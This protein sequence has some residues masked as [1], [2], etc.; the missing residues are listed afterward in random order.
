MS[1]TLG[2]LVLP[3][4]L[5]WSDEHA[6]SPIAQSTEYG[7]TGSLIVD[8]A[9]KQAGRPITLTGAND[10]SRYTAWVL[11]NQSFMGFSSLTDL[12]VAL[13]AAEATFTLT[14]HDGRAF[15][16]MPRHDGD[17][18]IRVTPLA[19]FATLPPADPPAGWT[20]VLNELRLMEAPS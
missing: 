5:H 19:G 9:V 18:P 3:S 8:E 13:L 20:Y 4:G 2:A 12:R 14:L 17:G 16:V 15:T 6:W 7:L 11:L 10:G 1:I